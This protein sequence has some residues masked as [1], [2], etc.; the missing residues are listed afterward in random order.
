MNVSQKNGNI[1][2]VQV[3]KS[4][5]IG[6]FDVEMMIS[7]HAN[8]IIF[9]DKT[10]IN[11]SISFFLQEIDLKLPFLSFIVIYVNVKV[12]IN[13]SVSEQLIVFTR[14]QEIFR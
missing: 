11:Y 3:L 12:I 2:E 14:V 4:R 7:G 10:L 8:I 1:Y 9:G 5:I 6:T 13:C